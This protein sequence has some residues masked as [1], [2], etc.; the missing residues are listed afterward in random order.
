MQGRATLARDRPAPDATAPGDHGNSL[1]LAAEAS[2]VARREGQ[3]IAA[4]SHPTIAALGRPASAR[5]GLS[6]RAIGFL[7]V[8]ILP[9]AAAAVYYLAIAADQYVAEFRFG[10]RT[11]APLPA[12]AGALWQPGPEPS[13]LAVDAAAIVQYIESR[14][15]IDELDPKLNLRQM[16]SRR[17]ADWPARLRG[18]ASI[19]EVVRY[20]RGQV[21][22]F[23]DAANGTIV[24]RARAFTALDAFVLAQAI[25][26]ASE[27]LV[28]ELSART[29]RDTMRR[30]EEE[31]GD[32]E[33]RLRA[34]L[35]RLREF[36]DR[37]GVIDPGKAAAAT[38]TLAAHVRDELER[39]K[40]ERA[41]LKTYMR[42]DAPS[43][44]VLD[45]RIRSLEAQ[46]RAVA[47]EVTG[48]DTERAALTR[49]MGT[50]EELDSE[51]RFAEAS[52]QHALEALDRARS[53]ADR[54]Q[55]YIAS[56]V[57]PSLPEEAFY[58]RRLR[59]FGIVAL[60]AFASWAIGCLVLQSIRDHLQ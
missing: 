29:R 19:E 55:V 41:T 20:W 28:N 42:D 11:P 23:D 47:S 5:R 12:R 39:A 56:F 25:A 54:Q 45:A 13:P 7:V 53:D 48:A 31:A 17:E 35:A 44:K 59:S 30:A 18:P 43:V 1:S 2:A 37:E 24:V 16:F 9:A 32:V 27:T 36:R 10:L 52:Y 15:I 49:V 21:D 50:Y 38:L 34:V 57:P 22:A 58:P 26:A 6:W 3:Q 8:V 14:A 33:R 46:L 40:A 60:L 51:R 4:L